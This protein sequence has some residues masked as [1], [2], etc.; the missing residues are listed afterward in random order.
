MTDL[1]TQSQELLSAIGARLDRFAKVLGEDCTT[2]DLYRQRLV[3]HQPEG[4]KWGSRCTGRHPAGAVWPCKVVRQLNQADTYPTNVRVAARWLDVVRRM[5]DMISATIPNAIDNIEYQLN[6]GGPNAE[7]N[8]RF[9][10][11]A[12]TMPFAYA[13]AATPARVGSEVEA[14]IAPLS[15]AVD[16][17]FTAHDVR[18]ALSRLEAEMVTAEVT[19]AALVDDCQWTVGTAHGRT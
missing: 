8:R 1:D 5:R 7:Y 6:I 16:D 15:V 4:G 3:D 10:F 17:L 18:A 2:A 13:I 14:A 19:L 11:S 12:F 9:A